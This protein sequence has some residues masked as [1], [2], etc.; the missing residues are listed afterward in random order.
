MLD[1]NPNCLSR[2][3]WSDG[4]ENKQDNNTEPLDELDDNINLEE[5]GHSD[6]GGG[7]KGQQPLPYSV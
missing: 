6:G 7:V 4:K 3:E 1:Q 5:R 2:Q